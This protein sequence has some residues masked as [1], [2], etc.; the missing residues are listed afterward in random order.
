M[1]G[2]WLQFWTFINEAN[3]KTEGCI[4]VIQM[5][6]WSSCL[7]DFILVKQSKIT[8]QDSYPSQKKSIVIM[9]RWPNVAHSMLYCWYAFMFECVIQN[10]QVCL[11]SNSEPRFNF[12]ISYKTDASIDFPWLYWFS[13]N[14][15][16]NYKY[17]KKCIF[18]K[19]YH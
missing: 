12:Y 4:S 17:N 3:S 10:L 13:C 18:S 9:N 5:P 15:K 1:F 6:L 7:Y 19:N 14:A 2:L 8:I 11:E 16:R